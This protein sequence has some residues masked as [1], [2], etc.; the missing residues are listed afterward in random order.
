MGI[1]GAVFAYHK[2]CEEQARQ[3]DKQPLM[4]WYNNF[5]V[6]LNGVTREGRWWTVRKFTE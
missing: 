5:T 6:S 3:G 2:Y 1:N 4:N